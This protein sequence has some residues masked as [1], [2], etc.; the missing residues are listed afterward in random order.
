M[1]PSFKSSF[2]APF[3]L[4]KDSKLWKKQ[5]KSTTR[6]PRDLAVVYLLK[7]YQTPSA[8]SDLTGLTAE[9]LT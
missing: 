8:G 5:S 3:Y 9:S 7:I 1:L 6:F 2:S 4:F